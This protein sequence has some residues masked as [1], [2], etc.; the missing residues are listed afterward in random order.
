MYIYIC[1]CVCVYTYT[2]T[3]IYMYIYIYMYTLYIFI[4]TYIYVHMC[5]YTH[6]CIWT[7]ISENLIQRGGTS[8]KIVQKVDFLIA[9]RLRK[10]ILKS[11]FCR[12]LRRIYCIRSL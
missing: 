8:V 2:Y 10:P 4:Y 11:L 5:I 12:K 9:S 3:Y 7:D 1:V 6:I